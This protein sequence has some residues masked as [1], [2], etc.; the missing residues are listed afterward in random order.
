MAEDFK[1]EIFKTNRIT[2]AEMYRDA[3][4]YLTSRYL[5][6][7]QVFTPASAFGQLLQVTIDVGKLIMYY[8][9]DSLTELNIYTA[10]RDTS[11][12]SLARL[13]G[14]NAVRSIAATGTV[15][16]AYNGNSTQMYGNTLVIPNYTVLVD[17][18]TGFSYTITANTEEIRMEL[19][20]KNVIEVKVTQ[21]NIENQEFTSNGGDLQSFTVVAKRGTMI[22]QFFI[23]VFVNSK[24]W[25]HYDS[26]YD[27]SYDTEGVLI[28]TGDNGG[29][30][31]TFGNHFFGKVPELGSTIRVEYLISAGNGGNIAEG[32]DTQFAFSDTVFDI[33]GGEV[34]ANELI[35]I[36]VEKPIIF[37]A[38]PEPINLTR[39]LA[40][41][42]SRS[43]VLVN[44]DSYVYF[45]QKFNMFSV[46]DAFSTPEDDDI[47]DD[48]VIY[49]FLI[50]D[51]NKRKPT[52]ADYFTTPINLFTLSTYEKDKIY[53]YIEESGQKIMNTVIKI[54][55][56]IVTR[57]V[58]NV[59]ITAYEGY[60]KDT[61]RQ[62]IISRCSDY[63]L[64]NRRRDRIPKSDLVA[65]IETV[66]GVDSVNLWFLS[67]ENEAFKSNPEN[68]SA[69]DIGID[70]FGD[71]IN[72]NGNYALI[73]GGWKDRNGFTYFDTVDAGKPGSINV[74]FGR[75]TLKTLNMNLHRQNIDALKNS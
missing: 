49:L 55:D 54:V 16:L 19:S 73:R 43:F 21:G 4:D 63:F 27:M 3:K 74:A 34:D 67:E 68:A 12:R 47:E 29:V 38:D 11:I 48:N 75:D 62:M 64:K 24:L 41:R 31:I 10:T 61:M 65:I 20:G 59:N 50:P 37:G 28:K 36:S 18:A 60:S 2:F 53:D 46:I 56:P 70:S 42:T 23:K 35:S 25:T 6:T 52:S 13:A 8:V 44:A 40:P 32:S 45:L 9:E 72:R 1:P 26:L 30:D 7:G 66:E 33:I 17:D 22:D 58:L 71:V 51:V 14:H 15:S 39:I 57:Y 5:Q 69:P